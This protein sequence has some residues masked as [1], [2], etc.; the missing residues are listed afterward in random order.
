MGLPQKSEGEPAV[1]RA[2]RRL[3]EKGFNAR[4]DPGLAASQETHPLPLARQCHHL[5]GEIPGALR[6]RPAES[7]DRLSQTAARAPLV[8]GEF[9]LLTV[10]EPWRERR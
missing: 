1:G 10:R 9:F 5:L 6:G 4:N 3:R 7:E 2:R 8:L